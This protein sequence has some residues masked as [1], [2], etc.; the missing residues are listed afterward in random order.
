MN[1]H[2]A[3]TPLPTDP[4]APAP[5]AQPVVE[6][7]RTKRP[8]AAYILLGLSVAFLAVTILLAVKGFRPSEAKAPEKP[9]ATNPLNPDQPEAPAEAVDPKRG[10]YRI[11]AIAALVGFLVSAVAGVWLM[12]GLPRPTVEQ[13]RTEA[14]VSL[15]AIGSIIGLAL[16]LLGGLYFYR[17]SDSLSAWLDRGESKE[18]RWVVIPLLMVILGA[19]LV[20]AAIQPARAEERHN[21]LLRRLVY[22][23]NLGLTVLLLLVVLVV[24]NVAFAIRMPNRLD[25]TS[26]GFYSLS[27]PTE[28]FLHQLD[29]PVTAY[30]ILQ[31]TGNRVVDDIRRLLQSCADASGGK[32]VVKNIN[33]Q[34]NKTDLAALR[35]KYTQLEVNDNGVLLTVGEDDRPAAAGGPAGR[36]AFIRVDEFLDRESG[37][38]QQAQPA[39]AGEAKLIRELMFIAENRQKPVVYFT[40]SNKELSIGASPGSDEGPERSANQLKAFLEK[41]YLDVRPLNFDPIKPR[42]P[43]DADIVIVA[44][45]RSTFPP[46]TVDAIRKYMTEARPGGKKGKL[47]VLAGTPDPRDARKPVPTGLEPLLQSFNINLGNSYL[48]AIEGGQ[49]VLVDIPTGFT[50]SAIRAKNSIAQTLRRFLPVM[51]FPREVSAV[52]PGSPEFKATSIL[53]TATDFV[54]SESELPDNLN[55]MLADL[56]H[57]Q[58]VRAKTVGVVAADA[59]P[60]GTGRVA[61]YG[62]G[63]IA[64]DAWAQE[65]RGTAPVEFDLIGVTIDWLRD[66]PPV[67]TGVTSKTYS[68]YTFPAK[69]DT[70]RLI[71]LP[72]GL[73]FL[74]VAG[75]GAGVWVIRRK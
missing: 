58:V 9:A 37:M 36:Y 28:E 15:L 45:P 2:S 11:G 67:P 24:A 71:W 35:T 7:V 18:M 39:F 22:G 12:V 6:F 52:A 55:R 4:V 40:Q 49:P 44:A 29:Q 42:V 64:S 34:F 61:V 43:D 68:T 66:R 56:Q 70:T 59:G 62:S 53:V 17:W 63:L 47:I 46:P 21:S 1:P 14:R 75:L 54:W 30:A 3:P 25:T 73:T 50:E 5:L 10:D 41:N 23:T 26:T 31:D 16:L 27:Q 69:V 48:F 51:R 8:V 32:F 38:G 13:Q 60:N 19:G 57:K 74:I 20:F 65:S 33:P 72:L